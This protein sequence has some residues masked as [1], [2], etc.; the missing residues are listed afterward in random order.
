MALKISKDLLDVIHP[1]NSICIFTS[2]SNPETIFGGS[3]LKISQGRVLMGASSDA[4][5]NTTIDSGLPNIT[6]NIR[7]SWDGGATSNIMNGPS[8]GAFYT[9]R[10]LNEAIDYWQYV[11]TNANPSVRDHTVS[12]DASRSNAIYGKSSI[13]QP[14]ALYCNIWRRTV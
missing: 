11:N 7:P 4:Q 8:N 5:L 2:T 9:S 3:W 10:N 6:G 1:V 13:V 14:P 12:F